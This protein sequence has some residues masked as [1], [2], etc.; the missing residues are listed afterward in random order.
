MR[1]TACVHWHTVA[2]SAQNPEKEIHKTSIQCCCTICKAMNILS[3]YL[4][5]SLTPCPPREPHPRGW[6]WQSCL[7]VSLFRHTLSAYSK[8]PPPLSLQ[9]SSTLFI[10]FTGGLPPYSSS[11]NRALRY[12]LSKV[13]FTDS[14]HTSIPSQCASLHL[15]N[16]STV[17]SHCCFAHTKPPIRVPITLSIPP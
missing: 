5:I 11:L 7:Q 17:H 3:I 10:H 9:Y 12:P 4:S 6:P 16:H 13:T 1:S 2:K 15:F 14:H 8:L